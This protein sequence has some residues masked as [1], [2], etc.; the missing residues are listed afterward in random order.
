MREKSFYSRKCIC[1]A[2]KKKDIR[3]GLSRFFQQN[4]AT[5]EIWNKEMSKLG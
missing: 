5:A 3:E 4:D 2:I 1:C